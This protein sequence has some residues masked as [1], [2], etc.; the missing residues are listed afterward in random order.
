MDAEQVE[1]QAEEETASADSP[2]AEE[3][4][5]PEEESQPKG[6]VLS[7]YRR[8]NKKTLIAGSGILLLIA[9]SIGF[10]VV[11]GLR[12]SD[13]ITSS[14]LGGMPETAYDMK[15][16]LPLDVGYEKSQFVKV[17][18]ALELMDEGLQK[19]IDKNIS[20]LRKE[21]IDLI[22]TKSPKEVKSSGGKKELSQEITSRLNNYLSK[23][24]IKNT[25]FTELV[26]L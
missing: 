8:L 2:P 10:T 11:P 19:E 3:T 7:F 20:Q 22:L 24:C 15:F 5:A 16:F 14:F 13:T 12:S 4:P 9:G 25:Y 18:I 1:A 17:T 26:I 6:K 23:D 21:V